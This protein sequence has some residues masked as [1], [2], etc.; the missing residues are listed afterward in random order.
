MMLHAIAPTC[1]LRPDCNLLAMSLLS[2]G[3]AHKS[4]CWCNICGRATGP[5]CPS[6]ARI[7]LADA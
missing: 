1:L 5:S 3:L 6:S 4:L 2:K 7:S